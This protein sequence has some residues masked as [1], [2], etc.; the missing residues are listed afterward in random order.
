MA[1]SL[2]SKHKRKMRAVKRVRYG[3]KELVKLKE[4]V[5]KLNAPDGQ[6]VDMSQLSDTVILAN[7]KAVVEAVKAQE[8]TDQSMEVD[9]K[10]YDK[11][12]FKDKDGNYPPWFNKRKIKQLQLKHKKVKQKQL[13]GK[14][15]AGGKRRHR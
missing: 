10:K 4:T 1:K 6:G 14:K 8:T 9:S 5:A 12:T 11:R 13:T 15:K 3:A 7:S 2:R